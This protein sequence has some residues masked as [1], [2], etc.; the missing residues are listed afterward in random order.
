M[1]GTLNLKDS[2][3]SKQRRSSLPRAVILA[4][5]LLEALRG[6]AAKEELTVPALVSILI[7]DGLDVWLG[8]H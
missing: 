6:M 4:P 8:R 5:S 2:A 1:H 7:R 3:L